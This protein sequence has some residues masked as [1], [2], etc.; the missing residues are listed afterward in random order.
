[1]IRLTLRQ[2]RTEA[3]VGFG[4]LAVLAIV[5]AVTGPHL[6]HVNDAFQSA[7]KAARDCATAPNPVFEVDTPLQGVAAVHRARSRPRSSGSSSARR[8]SPASSRPARSASPGPRASPGGA[9]SR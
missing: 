4:L 2:F 9:G 1:M 7:C 5:L 8:S 3:I 6:A